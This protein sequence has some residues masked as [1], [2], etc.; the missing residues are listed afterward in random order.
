MNFIRNSTSLSVTVWIKYFK[1][2][3]HDPQEIPLYSSLYSQLNFD[4]LQKKKKELWD[5]YR[6]LRRF[7]L[8]ISERLRNRTI[9]IL[10][11]IDQVTTE[12]MRSLARGTSSTMP[13]KNSRGVARIVTRVRQ[14]QGTNLVSF[15]WPSNGSNRT[16][17]LL[18]GLRLTRF[19]WLDI[20][21]ISPPRRGRVPEKW[22]DISRAATWTR[23]CTMLV[24][25][26]HVPLPASL[27]GTCRVNAATNRRLA[28]D[29][30]CAMAS[31]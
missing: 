9:S 5:N 17:I 22:I 4:I 31:S 3:I 13:F 7:C 10:K 28:A 18:T 30:P 27:A 25:A 2:L 23:C 11:K 12:R 8:K 16:S 20:A 1:R 6:I 26:T 19:S 15:D 24:N 14:L 29:R 21:R